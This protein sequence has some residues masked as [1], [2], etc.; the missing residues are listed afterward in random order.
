MIGILAI[1][2]RFF[3]CQSRQG[4]NLVPLVR[5]ESVVRRENLDDSDEDEFYSDSDCSS[6]TSSQLADI[7]GSYQDYLDEYDSDGY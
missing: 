1:V 5:I 6:Y 7:L 3:G 2:K 4:G